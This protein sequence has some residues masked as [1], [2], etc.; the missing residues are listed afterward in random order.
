MEFFITI[1][2]CGWF[3]FENVEMYNAVLTWFHIIYVNLIG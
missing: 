1:V 3:K 2:T